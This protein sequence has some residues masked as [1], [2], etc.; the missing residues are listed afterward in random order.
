MV[1]IPNSGRPGPIYNDVAAQTSA[2]PSNTTYLLASNNL[3]DLTNVQQARLNLGLGTAATSSSAAFDPAGAAL[4]AQNAAEAYARSLLSGGGGGGGGPYQPLATNLTSLSA[5][6]Y[7]STSFVKMTASGVFAL[8]TATYLTAAGAVTSLTGTA[9]Q[10]SVSAST[11]AVTVSLPSTLT[12]PGTLQSGNIGVNYAPQSYYSIIVGGSLTGSTVGL[13]MY[14]THN[15]VAG[16]ASSFVGVQ[17]SPTWNIG[18]YGA[19]TGWSYRIGQ[20]TVSGAS[21]LTN[22]Y[23]L[24]IDPQVNLT[25]GASVTNVYGIY[26]QG[27]DNNTFKGGFLMGA[28]AGGNKGPGTINATALYINGTA[29]GTSAGMSNPMTTLGDIIVGAGGGSPA[30]L[31][32]GTNGYVLTMVSGSPAWAAGGGGGFTNPMT[33]TGDLIYSSSGSTPARLGI[34]GAGN[35]L[36]VSGGVPVWQPPSG[37]GYT[38]YIYPESYGA[39]GNG[40]T[41]DSVAIQ[42]AYNAV[43]FGKALM[44][45]GKYGIGTAAATAFGFSGTGLLFGALNGS[46]VLQ[47]VVCTGKAILQPSA[48]SPATN[49][50]TIGAGNL[51]GTL[52]LP[53][54]SGFSGYGLRLSNTALATVYG[55]FLVGNAVGVELYTSNVASTLCLDNTLYFQ[56]IFNASEAAV[57]C[58]LASNTDSGGVNQAF[59]QGNHV[60]CNF[61]NS[62]LRWVEFTYVAGVTVNGI[63]DNYFECDAYDPDLMAGTIVGIHNL[64]GNGAY[65]NKFRCNGFWGNFKAGDSWLQGGSANANIDL[66]DFD[67]GVGSG[68]VGTS[69]QQYAMITNGEFTNGWGSSYRVAYGGKLANTSGVTCSTTSNKGTFKGDGANNGYA[70]PFNRL[71]IRCTLPSVAN[72]GTQTFYAY[73][74]FVQGNARLQ[75]IPDP[76]SSSGA[77]GTVV[78]SVIDNTASVANEIKIVLRNVSGATSSATAAYVL[79]VGIP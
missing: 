34:G 3:S 55:G 69:A 20:V 62:C 48:S 79:V 45:S 75:L 77:A 63:N 12:L 60:Y 51:E 50:L 9:N 47:A 37:G 28:A 71:Q 54:I 61:V 43:T 7:A 5:L 21:T 67:F 73:H 22:H 13:Y 56:S 39:V 52:T 36:T 41:D 40:T 25:G 32:A 58:T 74:P 59:L 46:A 53:S 49:C 68:F 33:N 38:A 64:T 35:V 42:T 11:G 24:Y 14:E 29:V 6:T 57:K 19:D 70:C 65:Q 1:L 10:V 30:R 18:T 72:Y 8:D 4:A 66:S 17:S 27:T 26:Q 44:L 23:G 78:E 76:I 2:A 16:G 15:A 31:G